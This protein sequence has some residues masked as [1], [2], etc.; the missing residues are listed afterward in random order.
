[1]NA[2]EI[3]KCKNVGLT[4]LMK[5][6]A[7]F[8]PN[9]TSLLENAGWI[10]VQNDD[11][12]ATSITS[13]A[14]YFDV[15]IPLKMIFG[16][17]EDYSKIVVNAK[18][19]LVLNRSR[20]DLNAIRQTLTGAEG[21][22]SY[23]NYKIELSKIEVLKPY[24]T[25]SVRLKLNL[26]SHLKKNIIM[27]FRTWELFEYPLL[28]ATTR[29]VWPIKT[30]NQLEKPRYILLAFQTNRKNQNS[31]NASRF[32]N[33]NIRNVKLFLNSQYLSLIHISEPTRPY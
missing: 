29:H 24:I 9:Q 26:L 28:P 13:A 31:T 27:T 25:L 21:N 30:S 18:H 6:Y 12:N 14:G 4:T 32:D 10:S 2:I 23:E 15:I 1:M 20:N 11:D 7:S 16:F 8:T 5:G 19:E 22:Q 3:D 33:C 17:A